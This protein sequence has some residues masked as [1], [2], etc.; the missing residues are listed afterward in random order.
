MDERVRASMTDRRFT[1]VILA[2]FAGISLLLAAVG[3]YGVVSYT[4]AQR[5]RE[6]SIRLALGA[7]P[8]QV[9]SMVQGQAMRE[10]IIGLVVGSVGALAATRLMQSLLYQTGAADPRAFLTAIGI[11]FAAAW[12]ASL[13]P[14]RRVARLDPMVTIRS[15]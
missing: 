4:A 14:A 10:V 15:E 1:M 12:I 6:M 7:S 2:A 9:R 11:L 3:I 13:I 5:A 8:F